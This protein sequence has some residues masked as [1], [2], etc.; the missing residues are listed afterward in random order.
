MP[1][2]MPDEPAPAATVPAAA[3]D[4]FGADLYRVLTEQAADIVFSPASVA[5]VL[6]M[7]LCGARGQTAAELAGALHLGEAAHAGRGGAAGAAR[8][9]RRMRRLRGCGGWRR[10]SVT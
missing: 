7:A 9:R 5:S 10:W 1:A 2:T 3:D 8:R 6:R 4:A